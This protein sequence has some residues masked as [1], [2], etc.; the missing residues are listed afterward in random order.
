MLKCLQSLHT[1]CCFYTWMSLPQLSLH[2]GGSSS[3]NNPYLPAPFPGLQ[4]NMQGILAVDTSCLA[5]FSTRKSLTLSS[6]LPS[7]SRRVFSFLFFFLFNFSGRITH[8]A[9]V[10]PVKYLM[11]LSLSSAFL[12]HF[13]FSQ[14]DC[15]CSINVKRMKWSD[16]FWW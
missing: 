8:C 13:L 1:L 14:L 11:A 7:T 3:S 5:I 12:F 9:L 15:I 4:D 2:L 6:F 16:R 10:Y